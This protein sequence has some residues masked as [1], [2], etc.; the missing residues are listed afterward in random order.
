M[1]TAAQETTDIAANMRR[2]P[3]PQE[4]LPGIGDP[5]IEAQAR[6]VRDTTAERMALQKTE[7]EERQKLIAMMDE[8]GYVDA[9]HPFRFEEDGVKFIARIKEGK[10]KVSV[11]SENSVDNDDEDGGE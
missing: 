10:R 3:R 4:S 8:R 9:E 7:T 11:R 6:R 1:T 2:K 5:E